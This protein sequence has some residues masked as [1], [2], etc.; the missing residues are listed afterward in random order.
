MPAASNIS[1]QVYCNLT[2]GGW[3][4]LQHRFDGRLSFRRILQEYIDGFGD[5]NA[6]FWLGLEYMHL[7]TQHPRKVKFDLLTENR[8]HGKR[9]RYAG[10]S[11]FSV[12]SRVTGYKLSVSGN[13]TGDICAEILTYNNHSR[14]TVNCRSRNFGWWFKS[15]TYNSINGAY[16]QKGT[17]SG[18]THHA[19]VS[20]VDLVA[21]VMKIQ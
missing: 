19:C 17:E 20:Y 12:G 6:E 14:F 10:F 5:L 21:S 11:S 13:H 16:G 8:N 9:W 3:T 1:F 18:F 15:C 2:E 4:Y 7:L